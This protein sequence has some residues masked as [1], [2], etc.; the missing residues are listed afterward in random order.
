[1][2]MGAI[3]MRE[4]ILLP[5]VFILPSRGSSRVVVLLLRCDSVVRGISSSSSSSSSSSTS[6]YPDDH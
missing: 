6:L 5:Q 2:A 3:P 1:M 4:L